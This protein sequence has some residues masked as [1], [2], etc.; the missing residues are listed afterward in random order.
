MNRSAKRILFSLIG[1]FLLLPSCTPAAPATPDQALED[2]LI[3]QSVSV[4]LTAENL[5]IRNEQ[6][7]L[8]ATLTALETEPPEEEVV[9][10]QKVTETVAPSATPEAN[11]CTM[12]VSGPNAP[13]VTSIS[14]SGGT[15]GSQVTVHGK[16]FIRGQ[17]LTHFCFGENESEVVVCQSTTQCTAIVP[18]SS[19]T[20]NMTVKA[21]NVP[22]PTGANG[23]PDNFEYIVI[24][25]Q[26]P[27][28]DKISPQE[29]TIRGG[30]KVTV[31]GRNFKVGKQGVD[32][33]V[34][35]FFFG[36]NKATDVV[37][38]ETILCKLTSP[39]GEEG[40]VIVTARNGSLKGPHIPGNDFDSFKYNPIPKYGCSF[41]TVTPAKWA[42]FRGEEEFAIQWIVK[43]TGE[44]P[45]PAGLDAKFSDGVN[46]GSQSSQ[47]IPLALQ[48]NETYPINISATAPKNPGKYYM[49]WIIEGMGC[50]AYIAII[51]EKPES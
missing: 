47:E 4:T 44:N 36:A 16:N 48:P 37:C 45:W 17:N 35:E 15:A 1:V 25:P 51:V 19:T 26:A 33:A 28:I 18:L 50:N 21:V 22:Q 42:V 14:P 20:G 39:P 5:Q 7:A 38:D 29:G 41:Y 2:Q 32:A 30:T 8:T 40:I 34:T 46:M 43:N 27:V 23:T 6:L 12:P 49:T 24:D 10:T 9:A 31:T 3:A 13:V 11:L